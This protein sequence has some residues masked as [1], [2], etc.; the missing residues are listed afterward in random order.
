MLQNL[1]IVFVFFLFF[2]PFL[3][4][5]KKRVYCDYMLISDVT[6]KHEIKMTKTLICVY[7]YAVSAKCTMC[8]RCCVYTTFR[9]FEVA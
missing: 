6:I 4:V 2:F 7:F 9:M 5:W 1:I 3:L 8:W